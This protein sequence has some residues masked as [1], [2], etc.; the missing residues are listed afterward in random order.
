[1]CI[2]FIAIRQHP[3]YPLI[4]AANR[5]EFHA[6]PSAPMH[7]WH[8]QPGILAGRDRRA[9][10]TW[11]GVNARGRI[12]AVTNHRA[13]ATGLTTAAS[14][15]LAGEPARSRGELVARFLRNSEPT[16]NYAEFLRDDHG[17]FSPFNLVYGAPGHLYCFSSA[18]PFSRP[19]AR[20]FHSI[21][22]GA[23]DDPWPK[24]SRGVALLKAKIAAAPGEDLE[25]EDL[26]E[27]M[28]DQTPADGGLLPDTGLGFDREREKHLSSIFITGDDYGTR[29]TTLLLGT[30]EGFDLYEYNFSPDGEESDRRFYSLVVEE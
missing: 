1:M 9:G 11:F 7:Y 23:P 16:E 24:M 29:T 22:N 28:K 30:G 4:I 18:D 26:S 21:S 19:L 10:G 8:D 25:S 5:D 20:G 27:V 6:R 3:R 2:L 13:A 14:G 17:A 15:G 12:A